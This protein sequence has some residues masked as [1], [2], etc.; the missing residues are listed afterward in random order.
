MAWHKLS[1]HCRHG[2]LDNAGSA[3]RVEGS[4]RREFCNGPTFLSPSQGHKRQNQS[5]PST[6]ILLRPQSSLSKLAY[7]DGEPDMYQLPLAISAGQQA[8]AV[9]A[10]RSDSILTTL[11]STSG[12]AVLHDAT[13][14]EDFRRIELALIE[15]NAT[16]P[17]T[18][19]F[20]SCLI[21][22]AR[23]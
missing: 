10:E 9:T 14:R 19:I 7:F 18:S 20:G 22:R 6:P 15:R 17:L 3:R 21:K 13:T 12:I 8:D 11:T 23:D 1:Q 16:V 2:C 5:D 4:N